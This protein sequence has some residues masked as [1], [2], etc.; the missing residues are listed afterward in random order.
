MRINQIL[1]GNYKSCEAYYQLKLPIDINYDVPSDDPVRLLST[2]VEGLE[3]TD[4]YSTYERIRKN[5]ATPRQMLKIMIYAYM[6]HI[7]TS[8][9]IE[10]SCRRDVNFMYLLE[11]F[12]APDHATIA[13]FRTIH[14]SQC[15]KNILASMTGVLLD[16]GEISGQAVFID[17]TKI[18]ANAN[19]YTFVWKKSVLKNQAKLTSNLLGFVAGCEALYGITVVHRDRV[20]LHTLKRLRKKLYRLKK[21][22]GISFVHGSGKK[23]S[24]LQ[25][26]IEQAGEYISRLR[27]Y[28]RKI[29]VCGPRNSYS[30][31]DPDATFMRMK[32]DSMMNGQL[33]PGYNVQHGVD[34]E[35]VTWLDVSWHPTDTRTLIPFLK[36]MEQHLGFKYRDIVADSG[37]EGEENYCFIE[38]NGQEAYIKPNNYE[39][40]KTRKFR[41]DI[42]RRENMQ[43]DS[44]NDCYICK[45]NKQLHVTAEHRS[46]NDSGYARTVTVYECHDCSGCPYKSQCI[47]GNNCNT[48]MEQRNKH[49][50]V[51][52]V[53]EEK[54]KADLERLL[55]DYGT[56][57]RMNRSIQAEGSFADVKEDMN[58]RQYLCRGN[59][60]VLCESILLVMARNINKLHSRIRKKRTGQHLFEFKRTA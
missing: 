12:P 24:P 44:G 6:N 42:S 50:N 59:A 15:C 27:E 22:E 30:K 25:R 36:D 58:F 28:V 21:E 56:Q 53:L 55:S 1:Q 3:L 20:S 39:I 31:T 52:K 41:T 46:K 26:S 37:Y 47:K 7:Y 8:R 43:Y 14:F 17:G 40:S 33:K 23:K 60:N 9:A 32:E 5:Q 4:L 54:R 11:G 45:N 38:S 16:L 49:L 34:S 48:P 29:H 18:E 35:Y 57:L 10:T 19:K 13:R 51:S 2:F